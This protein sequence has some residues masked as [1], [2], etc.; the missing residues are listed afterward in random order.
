MLQ[1]RILDREE[2]LRLL[3]IRG[4]TLDQRVF[5][6]EISFA[7][8][9]PVNAHLNEYLPLDAFAVLMTSMLTPEI[10]QK[11]AAE[12]VRETWPGPQGWLRAVQLAETDPKLHTQ[13]EIPPEDELFLTLGVEPSLPPLAV[14]GTLLNCQRR[15]SAYR[16]IRGISIQKVLRQL[17]KNSRLYKVPLPVRLTPPLDDPNLAQ[18]W[19][20]I[21]AY[22][23][24]AN[25][26][27]KAKRKAKKA[28]A[29]AKE[30]A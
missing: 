30:I 11:A 9:C 14:V 4:V 23:K 20:E 16:I 13:A 1:D 19:R 28:G 24:L 6:G 22:Q 18:W 8:G 25:M 21:E 17:W 7:F 26:R 5:K 27:F 3:Q 12:L 10:G 15:L 2:F 29:R